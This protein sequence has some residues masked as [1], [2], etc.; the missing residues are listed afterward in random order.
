MVPGATL[1]VVTWVFL[2]RS[3]EDTIAAATCVRDYL[4]LWAAG[5]LAHAGQI[6]TLFH[7][8]LYDLWLK[9]V[10]GPDLSLHTWSYPPPMVLLAI[11][12]SILPLGWGFVVWAIG[13]LSMLG[14]TL[15]RCG[16]RSATCLAILLSPAAIENALAGQNGAITAAMLEGGLLLVNRKPI[17]AG[18]LFGLLTTKPQLGLLLPVCLMASGRWRAIGAAAATGVLLFVVSGWLLGWSAWEWYATDVRQF[19]TTHV[20][21]QPYGVMFQRLMGTPFIL[22]RWLR[23]PLAVAY[24]VQAVSAMAC[25]VA[26]WRAWRIPQANTKARMALT[27]S[28]ALLA[29]PYG[30]SWD[31]TGAAIG[32]AVLAEQALRTRFLPYERVLLA[33][34]WAWPGW[35]FWFGTLHYPPVGCLPL[36]G[37]AF[38]AWRR[39]RPL[40]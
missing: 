16:L 15:R 40:I 36:I 26:T 5:V 31:M 7:P 23:A 6:G 20:L 19:M 9:G 30:F 27:G 37:V 21:E 12:L 2:Y 32:I 8:P 17:L 4:N 33:A 28:L 34:A 38:C 11:P 25:A 22:A 24:T 10:F 14:I 35:A 1:A 13:S 29:T 18:I 3:R 39:L